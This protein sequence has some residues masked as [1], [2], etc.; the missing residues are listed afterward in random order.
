MN[1]CTAI[2]N[3]PPTPTFSEQKL[4]VR[5]TIHPPPREEEGAAR[6]K[7]LKVLNKFGGSFTI[8]FVEKLDLIECAGSQSANLFMGSECKCL[9]S[10]VDSLRRKKEGQRRKLANQF[11]LTESSFD[12]RLVT[13]NFVSLTK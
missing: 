2:Q 10:S 3:R 9:G 5:P 7:Y 6:C 12:R 11:N 4:L 8:E 13:G 1:R